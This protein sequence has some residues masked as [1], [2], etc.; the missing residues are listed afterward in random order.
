MQEIGKE[1]LSR[2][3]VA[4]EFIGFLFLIALIWTS[5]LLDI[6]FLL[7]DAEATPVN[8]RESLLLTFIIIPLAVAL[9]YYTRMVFSRMKYLEGFLPICASCKMIRDDQGHWQQMESYIH[10]RS[11]VQFS[12]G[13]CPNCAEKLYPTFF[14]GKE[15]SS[16]PMEKN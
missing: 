13:I 2:K 5:E 3:V 1:L 7:L 16:I 9:I 8:W 10:S 12:H 14:N 15:A 6:P 11:E 4:S